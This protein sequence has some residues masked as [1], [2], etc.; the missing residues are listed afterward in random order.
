MSR[1]FTLSK[2]DKMLGGVCGG[3]GRYFG[4]DPTV[5]RL[6][7][8]VALLVFQ[9]FLPPFYIVLWLLFDET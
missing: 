5:I 1:R 3:I 2:D 7:F 4:I 6:A 8:V 9:I